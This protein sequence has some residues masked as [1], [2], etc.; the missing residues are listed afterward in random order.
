MKPEP[1]TLLLLE[2]KE[3]RIAELEAENARLRAH[4]RAVIQDIEVCSANLIDTI[5]SPMARPEHA[6]Y[7]EGMEHARWALM[8]RFNT[9]MDYYGLS[10]HSGDANKMVQGGKEES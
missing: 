4:V 8:H 10:N 2:E 1:N 9:S 5:Q 3:A 7:R 6:R